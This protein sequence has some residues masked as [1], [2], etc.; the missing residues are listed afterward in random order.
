MIIVHLF[1]G[2]DVRIFLILLFVNLI[3]VTSAQFHKQK[4]YAFIPLL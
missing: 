1:F 3:S 4:K 2:P